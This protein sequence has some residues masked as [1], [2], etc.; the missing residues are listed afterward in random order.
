LKLSYELLADNGVG[1]II[2]PASWLLNIPRP[3]HAWA[4]KF[5]D[6]HA[7]EFEFAT[8]KSVFGDLVIMESVIAITMFT[9]SPRLK[10]Q[11]IKIINHI[12][13]ITYDVNGIHEITPGNKIPNSLIK[14]IKSACASQGSLDEHIYTS[15]TSPC[16]GSWF[17]VTSNL[18]G[19]IDKKT[20]KPCSDFYTFISKT[21]ARV[22]TSKDFYGPTRNPRFFAFN[23][24][25]DA[26]NFLG[27]LKTD[28][29]RFCLSMEKDSRNLTKLSLK[30]TPWMDFT[31]AWDDDK[32]YQYLNIEQSEID[33]ITHRIPKYYDVD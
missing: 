12:D 18:T 4:R 11:P 29:A 7:K 27:Y 2:H 1:I 10:E 28:F 22:V 13:N 3:H 32:L 25:Q 26:E 21:R 31:Q 9:H 24:K 8:S 30:Y 23:A 15:Y 17:V 16:A 19:N 5:A 14:K 33:F 6:N 20:N